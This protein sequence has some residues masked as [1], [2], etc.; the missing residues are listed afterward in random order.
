M[1]RG[2][3][4]KLDWNNG[5]LLWKWTWPWLWS[6]M[7]RRFL[8]KLQFSWAEEKWKYWWCIRV[9]LGW[10]YPFLVQYKIDWWWNVEIIDPRPEWFSIFWATYR[11]ALA[12]DIYNNVWIEIVKPIVLYRDNS[13]NSWESDQELFREQLSKKI[14]EELKLWNTNIK[15]C[16]VK[17]DDYHNLDAGILF[18][19]AKTPYRISNLLDLCINND[20]KNLKTI[21]WE[22]TTENFNEN[23]NIGSVN[24]LQE[25]VTKTLAKNA[26]LM[27]KEGIIHGQFNIHF[28][29]I[30]ILWELSDFDSTIFLSLLKE[31][32]LD[33]NNV[34]K[35]FKSTLEEWEEKYWLDMLSY[36]NF[37]I[38]LF[39]W[40]NDKW[41]IN[42]DVLYSN[43]LW[44]IYD[45]FNQSMRVNDIFQRS[46]LNDIN[47]WYTVLSELDYDNL[48]EL[49]IKVFKENIWEEQFSFLNNE[50]IKLIS[51]YKDKYL[52]RHMWDVSIYAW[53][54]RWELNYLEDSFSEDDLEYTF[55]DTQ[56]LFDDILK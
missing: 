45:L 10:Q 41:S 5:Y 13:I 6:E 20:I 11:E 39:S 25:K 33:Q 19:H 22:L 40:L 51:V 12:G 56:K 37:D 3:Y 55:D 26:A 53:K 1:W 31:N 23:L 28:Q 38:K 46:L 52:L 54:N 48:R 29:N 42:N 43:I 35:Q 27:F 30:S 50:V 47:S 16:I 24:K 32:S 44:Q 7:M 14:V 2:C 34:Y 15:S 21:V 18:R 36:L 49:F 9:D 4:K 17:D 8:D